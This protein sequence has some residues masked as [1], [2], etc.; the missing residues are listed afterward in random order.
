MVEE[1]SLGGSGVQTGNALV[2]TLRSF[3]TEGDQVTCQSRY[4][5]NISSLII[6]R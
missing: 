6:G 3:T 5:I 2:C 4:T 1:S